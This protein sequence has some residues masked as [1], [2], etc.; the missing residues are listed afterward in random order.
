MRR[1]LTD[2]LID[3]ETELKAIRKTQQLILGKFNNQIKSEVINLQLDLP[4]HLRK[5]YFALKNLGGSASASLVSSLT[6][7]QRAVESSYL[8]QLVLLGQVEK[9]KE[10]RITLFTLKN[11]GEPNQNLKSST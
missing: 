2:V 9:R 10:D 8:N 1:R 4:D 7:R 5:T 11:N 6:T 3:I